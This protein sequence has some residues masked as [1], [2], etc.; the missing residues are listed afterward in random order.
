MRDVT[1]GFV[2]GVQRMLEALGAVS[3]PKEGES[4]SPRG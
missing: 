2:Q 1:G 3:G 4:A